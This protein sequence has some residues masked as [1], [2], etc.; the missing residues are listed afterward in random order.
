[1]ADMIDM[2]G[3]DTS[4]V[5]YRKVPPSQLRR[6][7]E[8]AVSHKTANNKQYSGSLIPALSPDTCDKN[9]ISTECALNASTELDPNSTSPLPPQSQVDGLVDL[10]DS[11][12]LP[13]SQV[14]AAEAG[15]AGRDQASV[16]DVINTV[17]VYGAT[18]KYNLK[19]C[20]Y[21][22]EKP[23]KLDDN[24]MC[25]FL[26]NCNSMYCEHCMVH[27]D[28]HREHLRWMRNMKPLSKFMENG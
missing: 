21:E 16:G 19:Q 22:C 14:S 8:R 4:N 23:L 11:T 5:T 25:C 3:I 9:H 18:R 26:D 1:M 7:K 13:P 2:T 17:Y 20:C 6:D 12:A 27:K 15:I 10:P 28:A 24:V